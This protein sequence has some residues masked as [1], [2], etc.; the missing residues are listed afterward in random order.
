TLG[1]VHIPLD[2]GKYIYDTPGIVYSSRMTELVEKKDLQVVL[3]EKPIKPTV[4]QLNEQ[5]TLFFG[6]FARFDFIKGDRQSFTCYM[7]NAL[8][9]HR[10]KLDRADELYA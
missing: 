7:S 1:V 5:Q 2:D 9:I 8:P 10:T 6:G 4:F 3:P